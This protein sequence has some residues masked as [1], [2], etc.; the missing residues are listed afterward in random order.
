MK[1][2]PILL[3]L[4]ATAL[5][6]CN[7]GKI[8]DLESN[9]RLLLQETQVQDSLVNDFL[10]TF[11]QMEENLMAIRER[12]G[13]VTLD[14]SE[15]K[16]SKERILE[17]ISSIDQMLDANRAQI[18]ELQNKL[19]RAESR[20]GSFGP[21]ISRLKEDIAA[22]ETEI[23]TMKDQIEK[24]TFEVET[25]RRR[26]ATLD[27]ERQQLED[28]RRQQSDRVTAQ[29][30]SIEEQTGIMRGQE[31][32]IN[33]AWYIIGTER[34]L[35]DL[36]ILDGSRL[37]VDF[38]HSQFTQIDI[39]QTSNIPVD[40]KKARILSSHPSDSYTLVEG[41]KKIEKLDIRDPKRFWKN[42]KYLVV[43]LN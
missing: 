20:L 17:D 31:A 6:S 28:V 32:A 23:A 10:N 16:T 11:N 19:S 41:D 14:A 26:V 38:D 43:V 29:T 8:K 21:S 35:K 7:Q 40:N 12:Q 4:A 42:T 3:A 34:E 39:T 24:G 27:N 36:N 15:G 30:A 9:N 25:Y 2:H 13:M 1:A 37:R 22:R 18:S 33:S 5:V